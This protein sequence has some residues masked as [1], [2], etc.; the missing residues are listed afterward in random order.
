MAQPD[1]TPRPT[2]AVTRRPGNAPSSASATA[3]SAALDTSSLD[4]R[5]LADG[6]R[7]AL[8][9]A[10]AAGPGPIQVRE[11]ALRPDGW[12]L[13]ES[14]PATPTLV[15]TDLAAL[16][17]AMVPSDA[18]RWIGAVRRARPWICAFVRTER[19]RQVAH[20]AESLLR[21]LDGRLTLLPAPGTREQR[22][23][24][25]WM[26]D[27]VCLLRPHAILEA[28]M[29]HDP[30][31]PGLDSTA[32]LCIRFGDDRTGRAPLHAV[33]LGPEAGVPMP[34]VVA[35][36]A[37]GRTL[38]V[39]GHEH[40][41][42]LGFEAEEIRSRMEAW[43]GAFASGTATPPDTTHPEPAQSGPGN[44]DLPRGTL[45]TRIRA[46]REARGFSQ[47]DLGDRTGLHQSMVSN[48]ERDIHNPR[49]D[50]VVRVARGL[51]MS[52]TDLLGDGDGDGH[53]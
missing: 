21:T 8:A 46:A 24:D 18:L 52:L 16:D 2:R 19:D 4:S 38:Q 13:D 53:G 26:L 25:H 29:E 22:R 6:V 28:H 42:V 11:G 12:L 50:T 9:T 5:R 35:P 45:G 36:G 41:M 1:S 23:L 17:R 3:T 49:L 15:L 10:R 7:D 39:M 48:L 20:R 33:G 27:L 43:P 40:R 30:V 32:T 51:G 31:L 47:G 44:L 14:G 37:G 34:Q